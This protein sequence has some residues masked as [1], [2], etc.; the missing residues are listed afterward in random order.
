MAS[1]LLKNGIH[2]RLLGK[3]EN[4]HE[5]RGSQMRPKRGR[6]TWERERAIQGSRSK[7]KAS[8]LDW[9][10]ARVFIDFLESF[11]IQTEDYL[12]PPCGAISEDATL[13]FFWNKINAN[14]VNKTPQQNLKIFEKELA[15]FSLQ[16]ALVWRHLCVGPLCYFVKQIK[17]KIKEENSRFAPPQCGVWNFELLLFLEEAEMD[18]WHQLRVALHCHVSEGRSRGSIWRHLRRFLNFGFCFFLKSSCR[19]IFEESSFS[20]MAPPQRGVILLF[21]KK[22]ELD[23]CHLMVAP[24]WHMSVAG[25]S[26]SDG[27]TSGSFEIQTWLALEEGGMAMWR[28]LR[29]AP[30]CHVASERETNGWT[31]GVGTCDTWHEIKRGTEDMW[32]H[33]KEAPHWHMS[34]SKK[35]KM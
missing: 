1:L 12:D 6:E 3:S 16:G 5:L 20:E 4:E 32:R 28:H 33:L 13:D 22:G 23:M 34:K 2:E 29:V 17:M 8:S 7:R 35:R 18:M 21:L 25:G 30:Q 26:T 19:A 9:A 31:C 10:W 15:W 11:E 14:F 24:H 27:A